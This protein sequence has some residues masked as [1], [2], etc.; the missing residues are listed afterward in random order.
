MKVEWRPAYEPGIMLDGTWVSYDI[1]EGLDER[2]QDTELTGQAPLLVYGDV[3]RVLVA[4]GL[5]TEQT[6]GGIYAG[7]AFA[8]FLDALEYEPRPVRPPG[9]S[10][11]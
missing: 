1:I 11:E 8:A 3:R 6:R 2:S 5:A 4:R 10:H 9:S 7:P